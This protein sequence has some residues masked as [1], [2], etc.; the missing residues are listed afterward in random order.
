MQ[1]WRCKC[2][3][4]ECWGSMPPAPCAY[5]DKCQSTLAQHP[6]YHEAPRPHVFRC[7]DG[8]WVCINCLEEVD[9]LV[10]ALQAIE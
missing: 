4:T 2:G 9:P 1:Y 10:A 3:D 6:D 8:R 7:Q 5:C